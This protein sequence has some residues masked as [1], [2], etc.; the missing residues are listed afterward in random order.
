MCPAGLKLDD[1]VGC[2]PDDDDVFEPVVE[3]SKKAPKSPTKRRTQS[4]SALKD[5]EENRALRK[6]SAHLLV[7]V[8]EQGLEKGWCMCVFLLVCVRDRV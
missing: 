2:D 5:K 4:L 1:D 6:V 3:S 8:C 7:C